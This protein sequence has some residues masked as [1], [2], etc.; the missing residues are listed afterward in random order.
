ML[1]YVNYQSEQF[2]TD[3]AIDHFDGNYSSIE[4]PSYQVTLVYVRVT[5][6]TN[7]HIMDINRFSDLF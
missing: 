3:E 5:I 7:M 1:Y 2:L 4:V 6:K